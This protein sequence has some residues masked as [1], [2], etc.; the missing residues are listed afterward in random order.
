MDPDGGARHP[1]AMLNIAT[2]TLSYNVVGI[3]ELY[4]DEDLFSAEFI[5]I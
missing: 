3:E 5:S 2:R 4:T 1:D